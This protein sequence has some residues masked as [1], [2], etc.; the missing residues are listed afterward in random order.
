MPRPAKAYQAELLARLRARARTMLATEHEV[1][2]LLAAALKDVQAK[3]AAQPS[4]YQRWQL[5]QLQQQIEAILAG[6]AAGTSNRV[7]R[8]MRDA[9]QHGEDLVD[10]PLAAG[11]V[12]VALKLPAMDTG[13][14]KAL[15]TFT[16]DRIKDVSAEALTSIKRSLGLVSIGSITPFEAV[17]AV[18]KALGEDAPRR[19]ITI[20]RTELGRAAAVAT[21]QRQEQAAAVVPGMRKRWRRSGKIHSRANHDH[22]DGQVVD[23]DKPFVLQAAAG[24]VVKM[25][26]PHDPKAPIEEIINCGCIAIPDVPGLSAKTPGP[27]PYTEEEIKRDGRKARAAQLRGR[28]G[29]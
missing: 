29:G 6:A 26:H 28:S 18:Q 22:A 10:K 23:V 4:D 14:L 12:N 9:W 11:G 2:G 24:G 21:Q 19:A 20:V 16:A 8:A 27:K 25:M 3:L 13:M 1:Q 7:D 15:R 17:Q 5:P